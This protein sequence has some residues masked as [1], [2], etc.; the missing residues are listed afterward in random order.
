MRNLC[1]IFCVKRKICAA[2]LILSLISGFTPAAESISGK[3]RGKTALGVIL[4]GIAYTTHALIKHDRQAAEELRHHLGAPERVVQFERGFDLWR[5]EHYGKQHYIFR[6]NRL[7]TKTNF[8]VCN[9][10]YK[11]GMRFSWQDRGWLA[12]KGEGWKDRRKEHA[13]TL[14][15]LHA[16]AFPPFLIDTPVSGNPRWSQLY[17]LGSLRVPQLV[18][19][20]LHRLAAERSLDPRLWLSH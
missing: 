16:S 17:L 2:A 6:N 3:L 8:S 18:V 14:L 15:H 7:L 11:S 19:S 4:F 12:G 1:Q 20:D 13:S 10:P 9:A 5:I